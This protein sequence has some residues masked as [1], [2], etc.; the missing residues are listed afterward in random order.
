MYNESNMYL[1]TRIDLELNG[2][3]VKLSIESKIFYLRRKYQIIEWWVKTWYYEKTTKL[4]TE[5]SPSNILTKA[6]KASWTLD[7]STTKFIVECVPVKTIELFFTVA[8]KGHEYFFVSR[9]HNFAIPWL[10]ISRP[11][12]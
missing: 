11:Q 9:G 1:T 3:G 7:F 12:D 6:L 8:L 4:Q 5:L 2:N 10:N